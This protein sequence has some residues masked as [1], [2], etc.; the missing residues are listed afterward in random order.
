MLTIFIVGIIVILLSSVYNKKTMP[1]LRFTNHSEYTMGSGDGL[2]TD[3]DSYCDQGF[4][5]LKN[6]IMQFFYAKNE[7]YYTM[8]DTMFCKHDNEECAAWIDPNRPALGLAGFQGKIY[9]ILWN[10]ALNAYQLNMVQFNGAERKVIATLPL[11]CKTSPESPQYFSH[12]IG[13]VVYSGD[14]MWLMLREETVINSE[15]DENRSYDKYTCMGVHLETGEVSICPLVSEEDKEGVLSLE[16][17]TEEQLLFCWE[18]VDVPLTEE[19]FQKAYASGEYHNLVVDEKY[20]DSYSAY[21]RDFALNKVSHY[22][23]YVYD[24]KVRS[25]RQLETGTKIIRDDGSCVRPYYF[26]GSWQGEF[27]IADAQNKNCKAVMLWDTETNEKDILF[28]IED[29][30][31]PLYG[32]NGHISSDNEILFAEYEYKDGKK[33]WIQM[34]SFSFETR[35]ISNLYRDVWNFTYRIEGECGDYYIGNGN[36]GTDELSIISKKDYREGKFNKARRL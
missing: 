30:A 15:S 20:P 21:M 2:Y 34:K 8:C 1:T 29:G 11:E 3:H 19:E 18:D 33:A 32:D 35:K 13:E 27:L 22:T 9:V 23:Y 4:F 28:N 26:Y 24:I 31:F 36:F 6:G 5:T 10:Q 17:V 16:G 7:K 25:I 14:Y 12:P